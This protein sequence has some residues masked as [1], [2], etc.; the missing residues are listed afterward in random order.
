MIKQLAV[1]AILLAP[2][3]ARS[4]GIDSVFVE[5]YHVRPGDTIDAP[6]LTTYRIFIDL[7]SGYSLQMVYGDEENELEISTSTDFFNDLENGTKF[8]DRFPA[9]ALNTYP[10][11]L[12]SW[13][14]IGAA[15]DRHWAVPR[16]LDANGSII[17]C[18]PYPDHRTGTIPNTKQNLAPLCE[19]D[20]LV[21]VDSLA[22]VVNM[23]ME[24][25]YLGTIRG[26]CIHTMN[27]GWAVLGGTFG[28]TDRNMVL[29]GQFTTTGTLRYELNMQVRAPDGTLVRCVS[30]VADEADEVLVPALRGSTSYTP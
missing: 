18:P 11:A 26:C 30:T 29:I 3:F 21:A 17:T 10:G 19:K 7:A 6:P 20:G 13:L 5:V 22:Q 25:G 8:G 15:T 12:D 28:I 16:E 2:A 4:Q 1:A 27:G 24:P 9:S 14:T 23:F